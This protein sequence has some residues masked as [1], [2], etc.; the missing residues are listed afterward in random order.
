LRALGTTDAARHSGV[1]IKAAGMTAGLG[2]YFGTGD[3]LRN[4]HIEFARSLYMIH[5]TQDYC[6]VKMAV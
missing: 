1:R 4:M 2:R 3:V 5:P 6:T